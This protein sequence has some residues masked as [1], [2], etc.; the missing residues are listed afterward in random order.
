MFIL[1]FILASK[2]TPIHFR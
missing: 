1:A 2:T